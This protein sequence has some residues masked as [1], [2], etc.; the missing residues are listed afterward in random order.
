MK[1]DVWSIVL[2]AMIMMAS[3]YQTANAQSVIEEKAVLTGIVSWTAQAGDAVEEGSTLVKITTLTGQT[4]ASRASADGVVKTIKV[5][6][7]DTITAGEIVAE[8]TAN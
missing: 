1:K 4:T 7:G 2:I 8:I 5:S 3:L 6:P